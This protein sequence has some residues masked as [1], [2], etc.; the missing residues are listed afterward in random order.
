MREHDNRNPILKKPVMSRPSKSR[1]LRERYAELLKL[2]KRS[3]RSQV[4][5]LTRGADIQLNQRVSLRHRADA[6]RRSSMKQREPKDPAEKSDKA[7]R[8][9]YSEVL[10]LRELVK[11]AESRL[12]DGKSSDQPPDFLRHRR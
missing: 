12:H 7:L 11:E 5:G 8:V 4:P 3:G 2:A 1:S 6:L 9:R 10:K